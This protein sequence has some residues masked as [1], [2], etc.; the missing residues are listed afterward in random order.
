M[1]PCRC[2]VV[3]LCRCAVVPLCR[4]MMPA[5]PP[6]RSASASQHLRAR[7][8]HARVRAA[9]PT[10][11]APRIRSPQRAD[12]PTHPASKP[13]HRMPSRAC[14]AASSRDRCGALSAAPPRA[15]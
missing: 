7:A 11:G 12:A 8:S 13:R 15:A 1:P 3:P 6:R 10:P 4:Q 9:A 14:L 5:A 2:A